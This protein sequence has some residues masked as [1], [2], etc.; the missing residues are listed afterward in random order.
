MNDKKHRKG[1]VFHRRRGS[2]K[3]RERRARETCFRKMK[4]GDRTQIKD[5]FL[6]AVRHPTEERVEFLEQV[7]RG[8]PDLRC[9]E[10][11]TYVQTAK[12]FR[13]WRSAP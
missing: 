12:V 11:P 9:E 6:E 4:P 1:A 3:S 2:R 5:V 7:C 8:D 10:A 13:V